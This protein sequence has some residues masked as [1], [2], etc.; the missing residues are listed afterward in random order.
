MQRSGYKYGAEHVARSRGIAYAA[1][2]VVAPRSAVATEPIS[3]PVVAGQVASDAGYASFT[4]E[5]SALQ[6]AARDLLTA[7]AESHTRLAASWSR[8]GHVDTG[9]TLIKHVLRGSNCRTSDES[10][11]PLCVEKADREGAALTVHIRF[12][13]LGLVAGA[14]EQLDVHRG[15]LTF[16]AKIV[17]CQRQ[18]QHEFV[19]IAV[20][21]GHRELPGAFFLD[22][23]CDDDAPF[24]IFHARA[25]I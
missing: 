17:L 11:A 6:K 8:Q 24:R 3:C 23:Q 9:A 22:L 21:G 7:E 25:D 16:S 18:Y 19:K 15:T 13:I 12:E 20:T 1:G 4:D 5:P 2:V 10:S 14:A